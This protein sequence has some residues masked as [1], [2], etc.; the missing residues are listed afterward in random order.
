[1]ERRATICSSPMGVVRAS[2]GRVAVGSDRVV[3]VREPEMPAK[4]PD[5]RS[6]RERSDGAWAVVSGEQPASLPRGRRCNSPMGVVRGSRGRVAVGSDR[7]V[8]RA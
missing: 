2:R 3:G 7:V 4:R 1:M 6:I 8:G 5:P